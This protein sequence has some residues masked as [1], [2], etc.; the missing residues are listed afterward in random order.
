MRTCR[1]FIWNAL[2]P[3]LG[4]EV[5]M[6]SFFGFPL[7]F[8]LGFPQPSYSRSLNMM[9]INRQGVARQAACRNDEIRNN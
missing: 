2:R 9:S 5:C 8:P 1:I 6:P 3:T 4:R 7:G